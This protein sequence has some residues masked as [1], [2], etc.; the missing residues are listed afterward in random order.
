MF[1]AQFKAANKHLMATKLPQN[2]LLVGFPQVLNRTGNE[3]RE[4]ERRETDKREPESSVKGER[5]HGFSDVRVNTV[6]KNTT[7][8]PFLSFLL[9]LFL[10]ITTF[11]VNEIHPL[12]GLFMDERTTPTPP[13]RLDRWS[14]VHYR[15]SGALFCPIS[16]PPCSAAAGAAEEELRLEGLSHP[17]LVIFPI[18]GCSR[19]CRRMIILRYR[20]LV[21]WKNK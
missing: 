20:W 1:P 19:D 21:K 15:W 7:W 6:D 3:R 13:L 11:M 8:Q 2:P 4:R 17:F 10:L 16:R 14:D 18:S 12:F 5:K 9:F